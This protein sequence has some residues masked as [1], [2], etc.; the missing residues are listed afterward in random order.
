LFLCFT[1]QAFAHASERGHV[2]LLP[3]QYY[4]LG[5]ALAVAASFCVLA[6]LPA[7]SPPRIGLRRVKLGFFPFD[8]RAAVSLL[9]FFFFLALLYAGASGSRDPLANPLPL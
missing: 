4:A 5:G 6:L 8:G 1:G 9:S 3:T 7:A 2:L